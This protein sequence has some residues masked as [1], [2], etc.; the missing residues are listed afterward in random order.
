MENEP[1]SRYDFG[2]SSKM[3]LRFALIDLFAV[4]SI[5]AIFFSFL[6]SSLNRQVRASRGTVCHDNLRHVGIGLRTHLNLDPR[7]PHGVYQLSLRE[8][9]GL[10]TIVPALL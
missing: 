10:T 8:L 7:K 4:V 2:R 6:P 9:F 1:E 3:K 5:L